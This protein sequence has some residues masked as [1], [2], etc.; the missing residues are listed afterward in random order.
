MK[1]FLTRSF[2]FSAS[3][4]KGP[5][6]IGHN[7]ELEVTVDALD[8]AGE[9]V[10]DATVHKLLIDRIHSRDLSLHA[11]FL[12]KGAPVTDTALLEAFWRLL[13]PELAPAILQR[14]SLKRGG[15]H[16]SSLEL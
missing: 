6:I 8:E 13:Q 16:R 15:G 3:H 2:L 10:L 12:L 4:E 11:D 14:L 9:E 5:K 7:Y 1:A